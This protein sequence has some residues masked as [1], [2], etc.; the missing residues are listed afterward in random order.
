MLL[1]QVIQ[2]F[3][4]ACIAERKADPT[5][6]AYRYH[7]DNFCKFTG[8]IAVDE[9][10]SKT[11]RAFITHEMTRE[12]P[13]GPLSSASIHKAF[14]VVRT[15][16]RWAHQEGILEDN[17]VAHVKAPKLEYRLP[18]ALTREELDRLMRYLR[19]QSN[20]RNR[21]IFEF[22]L[23]TG[24]RLNE[25]VLLNIQDIN[26]DEG[27]CKVMGK[28]SKE[29]LVP[30]GHKLRK[31]LYAYIHRYREGEDGEPAL[32]TSKFGTRL[33]RDGLAT[34]IK[35]VMKTVGVQ[36]KYGPHKLRHTFATNFL[37]NGG[38]LEALRRI[39]RHND[40]QTTL[41]YTHLG[42]EDI[43]MAHGQASPLDRM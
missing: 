24:C 26:L 1:K 17:P 5:L 4:L 22:F 40:I 28:G 31:D 16:L 33:S 39:L 19:T 13:R 21:V 30:L 20:F 11:V 12:G 25:V 3:M 8:N 10:T 15:F 18:E 27:H 9:I 43:L 29:G 38:S 35:R 41:I 42:D 2:E 23:D 34:M 6:D 36:G 32:F 14:S 7:L 37:R